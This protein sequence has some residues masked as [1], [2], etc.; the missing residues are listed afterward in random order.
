MS[1]T[2]IDTAATASDLAAIANAMDAIDLSSTRVSAALARAF[3]NAIVQGKSFEET[4]KT[5]G[6]RLSTLA[7]ESALKSAVS[8]AGSALSGLFGSMIGGGGSVPVAPFAEGGVVS[9][10]T[11]F[12]ASGGLGLMGERGAEAIMPLARGP[13]GRLGVA[14]QSGG[15]TQITV[16]IAAQDVESFRRAQGQVEAALARA[17]ARGRRSL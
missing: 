9:A 2:T 17:V 1:E 4:L 6:L 12:G 15:A 3:S 8:G 16:N 5:I 7:L 14:A 10:P 11:F 13:D